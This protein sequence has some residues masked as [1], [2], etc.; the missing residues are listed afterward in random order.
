MDVSRLTCDIN[1]SLELSSTCWLSVD[2][3]LETLVW[4]FDE[5]FR[6]HIS[7]QWNSAINRNTVIE[8]SL[9]GERQG[10]T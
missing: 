5:P 2:I 7:F 9:D 6:P 8:L 3:G 10:V 4:L 1:R